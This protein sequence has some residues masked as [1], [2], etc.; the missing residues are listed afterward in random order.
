MR[1]KAPFVIGAVA[2]VGALIAAFVLIQGAEK[3]PV[4]LSPAAESPPITTATTPSTATTSTPTAAADQAEPTSGGQTTPGSGF[5]ELFA[6]GAREKEGDAV[7]ARFDPAV[8]KKAVAKTL[9]G[10]GKCK[11]PGGPRGNVSATVTFDSS[12]KVSTVSITDPPF[13]GTSTASCLT[14]MLKQATMPPFKG[15]PG[16]HTQTISV[17]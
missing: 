17:R 16:T 13:A 8:A 6:N 5:A 9:T 7:A 4:P 1:S 11:E 10:V 15:L 14:A 3:Q 12:G 2:V